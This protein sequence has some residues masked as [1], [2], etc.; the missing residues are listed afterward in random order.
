VNIPHD[1]AVRLSSYY[2]NGGKEN[3]EAFFRAVAAVLG[4]GSLDTLP[5][6]IRFPDAAIYHP[7]AQTL[8]TSPTEYLRWKQVDTENRPP[9]IAI[10]FH[11][12]YVSGLQTRVVDD[13]IA[14][15]EAASA[16]PLAFYHANS[17]AT[18][19]TRMMAPDGKPLADAMINTRI[20][21]STDA[22]RAEFESLGIPVVQATPYRRGDEAAWQA[23]PQGIQLVD[24]PFYMSQAEYV[25]IVDLQVASAFDATNQELTPI[26]EQM[27]AV[28]EKA[29]NF[30][31]LQRKPNADKVVTVL[32]WNYPSG[33]K[34][35]SASFMDTPESLS[36][37][38]GELKGV[39]YTTSVPTEERLIGDLQRLLAPQYRDG[40]LPG[41]LS[42]GLAGRL[43]VSRYEQWLESLPA[44]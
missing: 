40:E 35:F 1:V 29:L 42:D 43:P 31:K 15:I 23:D 25:G 17:D 5:E 9:I 37:M 33:E 19:N 28:V 24:V 30:V 32:F 3:F 2:W 6:P 39:G 12:Q 36:H 7:D 4:G 20:T 21:L 10:A 22:P 34:N 41:L 38:L 14:R 18:A 44:H 13:L 16:V 8:F 11:Q 27:D 26:D